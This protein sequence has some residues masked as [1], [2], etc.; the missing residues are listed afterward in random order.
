MISAEYNPAPSIPRQVKGAKSPTGQ[1][2]DALKSA[3]SF[4]APCT[5]H[6]QRIPVRLFPGLSDAARSLSDAVRSLS[7]A[8]GSPSGAAGSLNGL[9]SS[10]T[11]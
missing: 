11:V 6:T 4:F 2:E 8:A 10:L 3:P 5:V 7:G 1:R 9:D